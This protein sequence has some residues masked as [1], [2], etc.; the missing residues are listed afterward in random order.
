MKIRKHIT[1]EQIDAALAEFQA[2]GGLIVKHKPDGKAFP[3]FSAGY[4]HN[5]GADG[6]LRQD[7]MLEGRK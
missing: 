7:A 4:S 1:Q 2:K 6:Y 5:P 3:P